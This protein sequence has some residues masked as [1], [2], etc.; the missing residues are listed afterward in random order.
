MTT[1]PTAQSVPATRAGA[2]PG[3]RNAVWCAVLAHELWRHGI[4]TAVLC[5][6]GRA[7]AMGAALHAWPGMETVCFTDERSAA[8][9]ALGRAKC[10]GRPVLVCTTSG[11]AVANALPA[12][13]EAHACGTALV[14]LSCD[15]PRGLRQA[16][17]P[18]CL[19]HIG[20]CRAVVEAAVDLPD[21]GVEDHRLQQLRQSLRGLLERLAQP[22]CGPVHINLPQ[23]GALASTDPDPDVAPSTPAHD[24]AD[25]SR[26]VRPPHQP[27][28]RAAPETPLDGL[29]LGPSMKGLI[30]VGPGSPLAAPEA[31]RLACATGYP[32]LADFPSGL[33]RPCTIPS[34]VTNG[35]LLITS[36]ELA[37]EPPDLI[38]RLGAAP[39]SSLA[40]RYLQAQA[41][42]T[43][44]LTRREGDDFIN[45]AAVRIA[46]P[47][48]HIVSA[49]VARLAPGDA[50]W[51][52]RWLANAERAHHEHAR[53]LAGSPWGEC[54]AAA[55][56]CNAEGYDLF[57]VANSMS[58]RHANQYAKAW[59]GAQVALANR[60]VSG[61][62]GS[63]ATFIG[64]LDGFSGCGLLLLGDQ[65]FAHDLSALQ[66]AR[67]RAASGTIC[68]MNNGGGAIFD[69]LSCAGMPDYARLMRNDPANRIDLLAAAF[70][71]PYQACHD[72]QALAA[73]LARGA[74][75]PGLNIVEIVVAPDSM[76]REIGLPYARLNR[77]PST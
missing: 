10:S 3:N 13:S 18:Q 26:L 42:L 34:L 27:R 38:I 2:A 33:R 43:L 29:G 48:A 36:K 30:F 35:D 59:Q 55:M 9:Y 69:V 21:P 68:V 62:D 31:A 37:Q 28:P 40:Q 50:H 24:D 61:I 5:M 14:L 23:H 32:V 76:R 58:I 8:F 44:L 60:G 53:L 54:K 1:T 52:A 67:D 15:R 19:D 41:C 63:I 4:R 77:I 25:D 74:G 65:A 22:D 71:L 39:V 56:V 20:L 7:A 72:E 45:P 11:S 16:G 6:G 47:T 75:A 49:L 46:A 57:Q 70:G 66:Y 64:A 12:L 51:R 17:A 73:A